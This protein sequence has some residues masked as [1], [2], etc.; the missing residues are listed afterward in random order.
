VLEFRLV[1]RNDLPLLAEWLTRPHVRETEWGIHDPLAVDADFGVSIDGPDRANL[2]LVINNGRP[3]GMIQDYLLGDNP[4]WLADLRD[5]RPDPATVGI[6]YL[7]GEPDLIGKGLG[8][9]MIAQ[10]LTTVWERYAEAP[11][12]LA[13]V[14]VANRRSW[15]ALE[16]SGFTRKWTGVLPSDLDS[17]AETHVY[18]V[19]SPSF[20]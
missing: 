2:W 9:R 11:A 20:G 3:V 13:A 7:I 8:T 5:T 18:L 1:T 19:S 15:R 6:D 10:F 4:A 12:I 14:D 17:G 16:K